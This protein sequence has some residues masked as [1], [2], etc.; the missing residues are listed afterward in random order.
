MTVTIE[1]IDQRTI[2]MPPLNTSNWQAKIAEVIEASGITCSA[3][4]PLKLSVYLHTQPYA[5]QKVLP[6]S[7]PHPHSEDLTEWHIH[8]ALLPKEELTFGT[9]RAISRAISRDVFLIQRFH[10]YGEFLMATMD[11]KALAQEQTKFADDAPWV[12]S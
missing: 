3:Q 9:M 8:L 6:T 5:D 1:I 2:P 7:A 12:V 10:D 4:N 11:P